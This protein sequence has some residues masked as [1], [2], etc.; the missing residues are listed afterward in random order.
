MYKYECN[1][2]ARLLLFFVNYRNFEMAFT[3]FI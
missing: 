2:V 3:S 1:C